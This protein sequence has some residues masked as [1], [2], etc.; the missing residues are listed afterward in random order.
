M[1]SK[2]TLSY[3]DFEGEMS[4]VTFEGLTLTDANM[5]A[6]STKMAD[7]QAAIEALTLGQIQSKTIVANTV[8]YA[9][10][11]AAVADAQR[12]RKWLVSYYDTTTNEKF[13]CELPCADL[14]FLDQVG[15]D[16]S[17]DKTTQEWIAFEA[18]F[19]AFVRSPRGNAVQVLDGFH[20]GR[21]V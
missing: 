15:K 3:R 2:L 1:S 4:K 20:V 11:Q 9:P 7:L 14:S 12:E 5:A 17:I 18:A 13:W 21:N 10:N 16:G 8:R 19:E 6:E